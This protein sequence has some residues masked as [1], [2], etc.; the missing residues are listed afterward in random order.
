[1]IKLLNLIFLGLIMTN[2]SLNS[3][4]KYWS[5]NQKVIENKEFLINYD[6]DFNEYKNNVLNYSNN[7]IFPDINN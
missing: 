5:D 1:L 2:C 6:N 4:S 7:S 3:S